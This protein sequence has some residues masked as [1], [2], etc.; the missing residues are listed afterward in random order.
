MFEAAAETGNYAIGV[1]GDQKYINPDVIIC[2]MVKQVGKSIYDTVS[3]MDTYFAGGDRSGTADMS[4]GYID[5]VYGDDTMTQ[6]VSDELKAE[7]EAHQ[8]PR[9][10]AVRS[11]SP[12]RWSNKRTGIHGG[13]RLRTGGDASPFLPFFSEMQKRGD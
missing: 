4:T 7:V 9:S 13:R 10:S 3:D 12:P 5:V 1:D 8:G 2:S 6:Q 11:K